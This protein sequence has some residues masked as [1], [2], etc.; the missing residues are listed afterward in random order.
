MSDS[1]K[2]K[3]ELKDVNGG[4]GFHGTIQIGD[5]FYINGYYGTAREEY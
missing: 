3:D 4:L 1:E 5:Y 2:L